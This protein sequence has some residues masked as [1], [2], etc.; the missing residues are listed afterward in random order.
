MMGFGDVFDKEEVPIAR[1]NVSRVTPEFLYA[2]VARL[3]TDVLVHWLLG[4]I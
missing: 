4:R 1:R 3:Q 2:I